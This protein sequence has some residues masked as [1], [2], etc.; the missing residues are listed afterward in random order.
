M[1]TWELNSL[2]QI[3]GGISVKGRQGEGLEVGPRMK[4]P[5]YALMVGTESE[6]DLPA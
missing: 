1:G 6:Q 4:C 5:A 2:D 3:S